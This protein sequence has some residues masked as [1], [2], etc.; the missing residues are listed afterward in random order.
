MLAIPVISAQTLRSAIE[1]PDFSEYSRQFMQ[2]QKVLVDDD[3]LAATQLLVAAVLGIS[4]VTYRAAF[5]SGAAFFASLVQKE[6]ARTQ[7]SAK[8]TPD[9]LR[10]SDEALQTAATWDASMTMRALCKELLEARA[11]IKFLKEHATPAATGGLIPRSLDVVG[12]D[13]EV[14]F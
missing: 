2:D 8:V 14:P 13:N 3:R 9:G 5:I 10:L 7:E 1:D 11:Q 6:L 12:A 4:P